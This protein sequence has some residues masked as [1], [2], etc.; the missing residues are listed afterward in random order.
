M[1]EKINRLLTHTLVYGLGDAVNKFIGFLLLPLFT[2]YLTPKDYGITSIL[3]LISFVFT[4][5]F[6]L[7]VGA[8]IAPYFFDSGDIKRKSIVIWTSFWVLTAG[9]VIFL[10]LGVIFLRQISQAAFG[11]TEH[12][13]LILLTLLTVWINVVLIPFPRFL[14]FEEQSGVYVKITVLSTTISIVLNI[15]FVVIWGRG[16]QGLIE[17][18]LLGRC[19]N[20]AFFFGAAVPQLDFGIDFRI[21]KKLLRTGLPLVPSFAFYFI[22]QDGNKYILQ[23]LNGLDVVGVY[24]IGFN[25]GMS[26]RLITGAFESSWVPFFMSYVDKRDEAVTLFGRV[27]SYYILGVGFVSSLV[28]V[29]AKPL[30]L[31]MT[32]PSFHDAYL[33]VGL[34]GSAAFIGVIYVLLLPG[35]YFEKQV[36]VQSFLQA[37]ASLLAIVLNFW[38]IQ[39]FGL[40]GAA[41]ALAAGMLGLSLITFLWNWINRSRY[42]QVQYEWN[43]LLK[44][45]IF[46]ITIIMLTFIPRNLNLSGEIGF[47]FLLLLLV[48]FLFYLVLTTSEK[49]QLRAFIQSLTGKII[50]GPTP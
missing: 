12:T 6:S 7:G 4:P 40:L 16:V 17:S 44:F 45:V 30:V 2:A 28:F 46:Y 38:L 19:L 43:R 3:A 24:T 41:L 15:L 50:H 14:Q 20:F 32:Q 39:E 36:Y 1:K 47:S 26:L 27:V 22:I 34:S 13:Y 25:F 23:W 5:I 37:L 48:F 8:A 29:I 31:L 18:Q 10:V 42:I 33:V 11:T 21:A 49:Q 9:S 35:M